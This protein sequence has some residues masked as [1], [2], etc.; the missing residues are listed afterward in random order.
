MRSSW[1]LLRVFRRRIGICLFVEFVIVFLLACGDIRPNRPES[2][3]DCLGV[4]GMLAAVL[5]LCLR[6]QTRCNTLPFPVSVR[7]RAWLPML[8]FGVL[9]M[10][11]Y[12]TIML[13]IIYR[14]VGPYSTARFILSMI[15]RLPLYVLGFLF[16][17][18]V[19]RSNPYFISFAFLAVM[20]SRIDS[21][22]YETLAATYYLWWPAVFGAIVFY[23]Y[24]EPIH[25]AQYD[26]LLAGSQSGFQSFETRDVSIVCRRSFVTWITDTVDAALFLVLVIVCLL[27]FLPLPFPSNFPEVLSPWTLFAPLVAVFWLVVAFKSLK[28]QYQATLASGFNPVSA[29][30]VTLMQMTIVL[31][32]LAQTLGVKKG[33]VAQ[34]DQCHTAKFLW[35]PHCPHCAHPGSGTIANKRLA[36]IVQGKSPPRGRTRFFARV[37]VP[38]Q[39]FLIFGFGA[40]GSRPFVTRSVLLTFQQDQDQQAQEEAV[41]RIRKLLESKA[42]LTEW[43][44]SPEGRALFSL[45][46]PERFRLNVKLLDSGSIGVCSYSL[47]WDPAGSLPG[48]M[49]RYLAAQVKDICTLSL[50]TD[51]PS[52]GRSPLFQM[53]GYLDNQIHWVEPRDKARESTVRDEPKPGPLRVT[54]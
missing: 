36:G 30:G 52:Y 54:G 24:E 41:N 33:V 35:D 16:I 22:W 15:T 50:E 4:A 9:C 49:A 31:I 19:W 45:H 37:F 29:F 13:A 7:Q 3:L 25:L 27:K 48:E 34:C 2:V 23:V 28:N 10:S 11:G 32:P 12:L 39:L 1:L 43:R 26:R 51:R 40:V 8:V 42:S 46:R 53:R 18:R 17:S 20:L 44:D 47:R 14:G 38:V 21:S 6:F 5:S